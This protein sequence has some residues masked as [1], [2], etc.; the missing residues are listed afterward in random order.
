MNCEWKQEVLDRIKPTLLK[1]K[2]KLQ[3]ELIIVNKEAKKNLQNSSLG[4]LSHEAD[5]NISLD[6]NIPRSNN[7]CKRILKI[8][9]AIRMIESGMYGKCKDCGEPIPIARL[10]IIPFADRCTECKSLAEKEDTVS[11]NGTHIR[12]HRETAVMI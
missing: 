7:L 3:S 1:E 9:E 10:M 11:V 8:N 5:I 6:I 4:I 2:K 12:I